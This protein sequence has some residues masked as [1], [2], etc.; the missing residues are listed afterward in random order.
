MIPRMHVVSKNTG[1]VLLRNYALRNQGQS[2][3]KSYRNFTICANSYQKAG[4]DFCWDRKKKAWPL[5]E[6]C[7]YRSWQ[8]A[9]LNLEKIDA[10]EKEIKKIVLNDSN[11]KD[12]YELFT[13]IKG[14][15]PVI[16]KNLVIK[17]ENFKCITTAKKLQALPVY[18]L[19]QFFRKNVNEVQDQSYGRQKT[20]IIVILSCKNHSGAQ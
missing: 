14:I 8:R 10:I 11:L 2:R 7:A 20:K 3:S 15:G 16:A 18:V 6:C 19:I 4:H 13:T 9:I 5:P 17:T 1:R 12:S